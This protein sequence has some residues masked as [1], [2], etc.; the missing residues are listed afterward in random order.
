V[1]PIT[2]G[3]L[4]TDLGVLAALVLWFTWQASVREDRMLK[5]LETLESYI[6]DTMTRAL[7]ANTEVMSRLEDWLQQREVA[8]KR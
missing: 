5:R 7:D 3:K 2:L 8:D 4:A 1:D 6:R